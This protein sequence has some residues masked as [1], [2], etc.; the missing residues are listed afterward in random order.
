MNKSILIIGFYI[1]RDLIDITHKYGFL[2]LLIDTLE[3]VIK[4]IRYE[5]FAAILIDRRYN[6]SIDILEFI[7][8]IRDF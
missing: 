4:K 3:K 1:H 2:L 6:I 8:N 5:K 7:L